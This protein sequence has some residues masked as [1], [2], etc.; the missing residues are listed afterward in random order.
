MLKP[1]FSW[2]GKMEDKFFVVTSGRYN[3]I[4]EH[5][6]SY[7]ALTMDVRT[8]NGRRPVSYEVAKKRAIDIVSM[9]EGVIAYVA[10]LKLEIQQRP[11]TK[12]IIIR[13]VR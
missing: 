11:V 4:T 13:R 7:P 8:T 6:E 10:E 1:P 3:N 9:E 5:V 12:P 2:R